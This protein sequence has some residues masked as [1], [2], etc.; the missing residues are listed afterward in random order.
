MAIA[1][2]LRYILEE[3]N[4]LDQELRHAHGQG[5]DRDARF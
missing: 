4:L 5:N 3:N 2:T 1:S